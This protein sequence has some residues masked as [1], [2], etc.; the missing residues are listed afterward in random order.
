MALKCGI[1]GLPNV[2]KSTFFNALTSAV[3]AGAENFPFCTIDPNVGQVCVPDERLD[4]IAK[5]ANSQKIIPTSIDFV[6]IAGLVRGASQ[7][8]GLGNQFLAHIREANA[9]IHMLRCFRDDN[10]THVEGGVDPLRDLEI[11]ET[12][13]MLADMESLDKRLQSL[14]K[15]RKQNDKEAKELVPLFEKA[16]CVLH[17]GVMLKAASWN[18]EEKK[19]LDRS[20]LLTMKP[21][22]Y[23]CNVSETD[24]L[25]GNDSSQ[26]IE[27][28][29]AE[30]GEEAL[31]ISV[32]IEQ[33]ISALPQEE[34]KNFL[35]EMGLEV[36]GLSRVIRSAYHL[37]GLLT[38]FTAGPKEARAWTMRKGGCAPQAAGV[39]HTDFERGFI[40]AE[41]ISF[42]DY[43]SCQGEAGAKNAGKMRQEGKNYQV[44]DGDVFHF[45][46]NV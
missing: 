39:I 33:E 44:Q 42:E 8:E 46:F 24:I 1:M 37:L 11:I 20:Q 17:D 35:K 13:L 19:L 34:Q 32:G 30:R 43:T 18:L 5:L 7:G 38:F 36:S 22:I 41:T 9:V 26:A 4:H 29:A 40:C 3:S 23:V 10:I 15:K 2:G 21:T 6:D 14:E 16:R 25:S 45:R 31:V 27:A 28:L 12:E